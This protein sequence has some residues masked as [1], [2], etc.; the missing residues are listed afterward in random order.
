MGLRISQMTVAKPFTQREIESRGRFGFVRAEPRKTPPG[1]TTLGEGG[2]KPVGENAPGGASGKTG[3]Q[4]TGHWDEAVNI[5]ARQPYCRI[6]T[7]HDRA[8]CQNEIGLICRLYELER[9]VEKQETNGSKASA[10]QR[11]PRWYKRRQPALT[12]LQKAAQHKDVELSQEQRQLVVEARTELR[13]LPH[14]APSLEQ[15]AAR[16]QAKEASSDDVADKTSRLHRRNG[17]PEPG[18]AYGPQVLGLASPDVVRDA[19][20]TAQPYSGVVVERPISFADSAYTEV[21]MT[22]RDRYQLASRPGCIK[23]QALTHAIHRLQALASQYVPSLTWEGRNIPPALIDFIL[24]TL[25]TAKIKHPGFAENPSKFR[26][27]LRKAPRKARSSAGDRP[28]EADHL[29]RDRGGDHDLRL[30]DCSEAPISRAQ[31]DLGFPGDVS[32]RCG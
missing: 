32:D 5:L 28:D 12:Q 14:L 29:A 27:L 18:Q 9:F 21:F 15:E 16:L 24:E 2:A 1:G 10:F 4:I 31:P 3:E 26:R 30:T 13:K 22:L 11:A 6:K 7:A 19:Q 23:S 20:A 17:T 8:R 25:D